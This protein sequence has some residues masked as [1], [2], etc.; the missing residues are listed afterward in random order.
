MRKRTQL[1][2]AVAT[3]A[4]LAA[5]GTA[6]AGAA[7]GPSPAKPGSVAAKTGEKPADPRL[8]VVAAQLGVTPGVLEGALL[9]A[10][11]SLS[12]ADITPDAF[13]AAVAAHL[14]LPVAQVGD[15]LGSQTAGPVRDGDRKKAGA[16]NGTDKGV[17]PSP[18]DSDASAAWLA[19][20]LGVT[21][22]DAK[23]ALTAVVVLG[24]SADGIDTGSA[25]FAGIA[26]DLGVSVDQLRTALGDLKQSLDN[27]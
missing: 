13:A 15:A 4:A 22:A 8:A 24:S 18:F 3:I 20:A 27:S 1:A 21:Q 14:G 5:T 25:E 2:A 19:A 26:A 6:A 16:R 10:K 11:A 7:P 23:A 17:D 9:A 12:S